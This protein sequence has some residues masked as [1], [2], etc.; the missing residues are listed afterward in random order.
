MEVLTIN[1]QYFRLRRPLERRI[2][3]LVRKHVGD[4]NAPFTIGIA[5]LKK[6]VGS[7]SPDKK[8]KFFL[9]QIALDGHIPDY[10]FELH[11]GNVVFKAQRPG[12]SKGQVEMALGLPATPSPTLLEKARRIAPGLDIYALYQEWSAFAQGQSEP[13]RNIDAAFL[14][15]CKKKS[16][17]SAS[18]R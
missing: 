6:K 7:N 12:F 1:P 5:K 2:Y 14:G 15:F 4:R 10:N 16:G 17:Q 9:K 8:F 3:E 11:D 13:P 18:T